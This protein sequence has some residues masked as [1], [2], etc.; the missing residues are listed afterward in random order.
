V[1]FSDVRT[2]FEYSEC[3]EETKPQLA[4][5]LGNLKIFGS[6]METKALDEL[7]RINRING[8]YPQW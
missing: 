6:D 8:Q 4:D 2:F 3:N 7:V 1:G 5:L